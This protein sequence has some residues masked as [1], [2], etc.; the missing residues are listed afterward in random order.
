MIDR[1]VTQ[2]EPQL[3]R[4]EFKIDSLTLD[5]RELQSTLQSIGLLPLEFPLYVVTPET[6]E[7]EVA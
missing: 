3:D 6:I 7:D 4:L 5:V 2:I 1:E